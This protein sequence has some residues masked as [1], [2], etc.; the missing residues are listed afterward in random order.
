VSFVHI[1][2]ERRDG[3]FPQTDFKSSSEFKWRFKFD[4]ELALISNFFIIRADFYE[5]N[6]LM[7]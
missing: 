1:C 3:D 2:A 5:S 4:E 6:N 7:N